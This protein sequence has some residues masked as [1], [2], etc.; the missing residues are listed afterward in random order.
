MKIQDSLIIRYYNLCTDVHPDEVARLQKLLDDGVNP[1]DVKMMLAHEITELY[2]GKE[3]ADQAEEHF[4]LVY[5]KNQIPKD[6]PCL[7]IDGNPAVIH[8]EQLLN[9]LVAGNYYKTK[10]EARRIFIQGGAQLNGERVTDIKAIALQ[11]GEEYA[12]K[13]GKN[14]FFKVRIK[15]SDEENK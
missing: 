15:A 13:L 14:K 4:K 8:G 7:E 9:A 5:Q 12:L 6:V 10:S 2:A 11:P 3:A 1:R